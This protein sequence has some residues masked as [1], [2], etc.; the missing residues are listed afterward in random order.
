MAKVLNTN[1]NRYVL[2]KNAHKYGIVIGNDTELV[3]EPRII[4]PKTGR[5]VLLKNSHK[6]GI[7][8]NV[9]S[10]KPMKPTKPEDKSEAIKPILEW[11]SSD[12]IDD[13]S[14]EDNTND[15]AREGY[16]SFCE[17][18]L[19]ITEKVKYVFVGSGYADRV[20]ADEE[21]LD[22]VKENN[23]VIIFPDL[24]WEEDMKPH[25]LE[26]GEHVF[27][28]C[29]KL[30]KFCLKRGGIV[31]KV[32]DNSNITDLDYVE[33]TGDLGFCGFCNMDCTDAKWYQ[34][35]SEVIVYMSIDTESG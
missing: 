2:A 9:E 22:E 35:G 15:Q 29:S 25:I 4:N 28:L 8:I 31:Y 26:D 33:M 18:N 20:I 16:I 34:I 11:C 17:E 6:Y 10:I 1:T 12:Y 32:S 23:A 5:Y 30:P 27:E 3:E 24:Y 7:D 13:E 21:L 14:E 19:S